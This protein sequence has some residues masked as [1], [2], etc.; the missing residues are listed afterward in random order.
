MNHVSVLRLDARSGPDLDVGRPCVN[1]GSGGHPD[2]CD[3]EGGQFGI[4]DVAS[5]AA[6]GHDRPE[7]EPALVV[8]ERRPKPFRRREGQDSATL[9]EIPRIVAAA[10][11]TGSN[12]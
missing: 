3:D 11:F 8:Q 7:R 9:R 10:R 4:G 6:L 2:D 12:G 1:D 5:A